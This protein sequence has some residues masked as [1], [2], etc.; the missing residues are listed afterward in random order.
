MTNEDRKKVLEM[1]K[2]IN[3]QNMFDRAKRNAIRN[4]SK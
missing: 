4:L 1:T 3:D 2:R